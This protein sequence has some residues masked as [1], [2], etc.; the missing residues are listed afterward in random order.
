MVKVA[1]NRIHLGELAAQIA[2]IA[3]VLAAEA[4]SVPVEGGDPLLAVF[5]IP[6]PDTEPLSQQHLAAEAAR[7]VPT[8]MLPR[9]IK[10]LPEYPLTSSGKPDRQSLREQARQILLTDGKTA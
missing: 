7:R 5:V 9:L 6:S 10:V 4:V 2:G 1:G 3:G 8:Y